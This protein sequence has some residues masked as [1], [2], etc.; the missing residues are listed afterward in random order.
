MSDVITETQTAIR[1]LRY[2]A[3]KTKREHLRHVISIYDD[4]DPNNIQTRL[5]QETNILW[6]YL[7]V[8][9]DI[10]R[11][12][13]MRQTAMH[14]QIQILASG[15]DLETQKKISRLDYRARGLKRK[16][17]YLQSLGEGIDDKINR[18]DDDRKGEGGFAPKIVRRD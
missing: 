16:V 4:K 7:S 10:L 11:I 5:A 18:D 15:S 6:T 14:K 9:I 17:N 13:N 3:E 8:T 2:W 12:V 1:E